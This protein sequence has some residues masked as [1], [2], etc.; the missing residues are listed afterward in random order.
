M[1]R[2]KHRPRPRSETNAWSAYTPPVESNIPMEHKTGV[3]PVRREQGPG[4]SGHFLM[5]NLI[6]LESEYLETRD[7]LLAWSAIMKA[8]EGG[9]QLPNFATDYLFQAACNIVDL[10]HHYGE[11]KEV[12]DISV[13]VAEALQF[14]RPGRGG[15]GHVFSA[16]AKRSEAQMIAQ[17][18]GN[19]IK[20]G[21]KP[22]IA[23][24]EIAK[25]YEISEAKVYKAL[26]DHGKFGDDDF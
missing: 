26:K 18:V 17:D 10:S 7:P 9:V 6:N 3:Q 21:S 5:A 11:G 14:K 13:A 16:D 22:Y 19:E 20:Y 12:P 15:S 4:P 8:L 25:R 23:V 24:S 1:R 2:N